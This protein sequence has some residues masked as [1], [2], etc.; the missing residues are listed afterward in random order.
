[1]FYGVFSCS[2]GFSH[3]LWGFFMFCGVFSCSMGF[4]SRSMGLELAHVLL[5]CEE[6]VIRELIFLRLS[7]DSPSP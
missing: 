7:G 5:R 2:M 4:F 3:V 6:K 1:M